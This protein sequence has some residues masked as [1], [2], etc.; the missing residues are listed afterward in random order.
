MNRFFPTFAICSLLLLQGCTLTG[1][2]DAGVSGEFAQP[3]KIDR[4]K[5]T[6]LGNGL[7]PE[8]TFNELSAADQRLALSAEY[9]ALEEA[10]AGI[11][12]SWQSK[13]GGAGSVTAS[14]PFRVGSTSCR[15]YSHEYTKPAGTASASSK[16]QGT[17]CRDVQ[18]LWTPVD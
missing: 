9:E 18:A 11:A 17:A 1:S 2:Q 16:G 15:Q 8:E 3:K 14:T 10:P 7:L 6:A 12:V 4:A 5:L 13:T